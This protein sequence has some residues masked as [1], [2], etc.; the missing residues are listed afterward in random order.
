MS[1]DLK[2][3]EDLLESLNSVLT[4]IGEIVQKVGDVRNSLNNGLHAE[5]AKYYSPD[6][7]IFN[8][9]YNNWKNDMQD[10]IN[11]VSNAIQL[12]KEEDSNSSQSPEE[13]EPTIGENEALD[14]NP[15]GIS[16]A[17]ISETF[18]NLNLKADKL[19]DNVKSGIVS[20]TATAAGLIK[21]KIS[22]TKA[23][24]TD[25]ITSATITGYVNT[26]S[27]GLNVRDENGN[28]IGSLPKG[29]AVNYAESKTDE[30]GNQWYKINYNGQ[31]AYVSA[32]Y[33]AN[34]DNPSTGATQATVSTLGGRLNVRDE[35]G[36]IITSI[37]NG[38][39]VNV[40]GQTEDGRTIIEWGDGDTAYVSSKYVNDSTNITSPI[41]TPTEATISKSYT[42]SA[43]S[44]N[45][46]SG[47]STSNDVISSYSN[48]S[49]INVIGEEGNWYQV[50]LGDGNTGFVYK[51]YLTE[52]V[53]GGNNE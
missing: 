40:V 36:N 47:P 49:N 30:N 11:N 23:N 38:A 9:C 53:A 48:G 29:A 19:I 26:E 17:N 20:A 39:E 8:D 44:L 22:T 15:T 52:N 12:Y 6:L 43:N 16:S 24:N 2:K 32:D 50:D 1:F 33:I 21:E 51:D 4:N 28:V 34:S 14:I 37:S 7:S 31:E 35:N 5:T 41:S 42:V 10:I 27:T 3:A 18:E 45:V 25:E 46:R 13:I